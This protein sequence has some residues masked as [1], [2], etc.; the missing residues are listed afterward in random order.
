MY[1]IILSTLQW[2][3]RLKFYFLVLIKTGIRVSSKQTLILKARRDVQN[4]QLCTVTARSVWIISWHTRHKRVSLVGYT[5]QTKS[6]IKVTVTTELF[7]FL[8]LVET[9]FCALIKYTFLDSVIN[10]WKISVRFDILRFCV[11]WITITEY[12]FFVFWNLRVLAFD[13]KEGSCKI[14]K[15]IWNL[16]TEFRLF[17]Q[18]DEY[19][20]NFDYR[21]KMSKKLSKIKITET[22]LFA[23]LNRPIRW[24]YEYY[25]LGNLMF[26]CFF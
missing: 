1:S 17:P 12:I 25:G 19:D 9:H 4:L 10:R 5:R 23:K 24:W 16:S 11:H 21:H 22:S 13:K 26:F 18:K 3:R 2:Q 7:Q 6:K 15:W 14:T 8:E 20:N